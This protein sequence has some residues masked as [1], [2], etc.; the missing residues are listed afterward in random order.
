M[1]T[2]P[3]DSIAALLDGGT[4]QPADRQRDVA[5]FNAR[6]DAE[7]RIQDEAGDCA[8]HA[9]QDSA[10]INRMG[11]FG[12]LRLQLPGAFLA[13]EHAVDAKVGAGQFLLTAFA[14]IGTSRGLVF[15]RAE[16][17]GAGHGASVERGQYRARRAQ[18]GTRVTGRWLKS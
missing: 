8:A 13:S 14:T 2:A 10:D 17:R 16:L 9:K 18:R 3:A 15:R 7:G 12:S 6:N 4:N 1:I 11:V 5:N